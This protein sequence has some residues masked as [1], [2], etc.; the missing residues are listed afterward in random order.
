MRL[1]LSPEQLQAVI[2]AWPDADDS[3]QTGLLVINNC[4]NEVSH[5]FRIAPKDWPKWFD[6]PLSEVQKTYEAWLA[7]KGIRGGIM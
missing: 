2:A 6:V 7:L 5:G 4:L 3:T 1:G